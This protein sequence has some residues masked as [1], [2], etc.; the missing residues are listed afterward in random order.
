MTIYRRVI[1]RATSVVAETG[2]RHAVVGITF[3]MDLTRV[4]PFRCD[5]YTRAHS[6][7][8]NNTTSR[9]HYVRI[10]TYVVTVR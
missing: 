3:A 7:P 1:R 2:N 8:A 6:R 4:F 9:G 5:E 10:V